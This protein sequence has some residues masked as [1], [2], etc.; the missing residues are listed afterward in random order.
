MPCYNDGIVSAEALLLGLAVGLGVGVLLVLA[1]VRRS[2]G[3][4]PPPL[5]PRVEQA[6]SSLPQLQQDLGGMKATLQG[7]PS[8]AVVHELAVR[9]ASLESQVGERV[10]STLPTDLQGLTESLTRLKT[11]LEERSKRDAALETTLRKIEGVV[12][13]AQ[14][15]GAAGEVVLAEAFANFPAEMA[16]HNFKVNGK[17]VEF[18]LV[19][20]NRKRLP[21]D[22]KWP[23]SKELEQYANASE[24]AERKELLERI[25]RAVLRKVEEVTKYI[26][27]ASTVNAAVAAVPDAAY[28]ACRTAHIEAYQ[29]RVLLMPYSLT[30]PFLL[31]LYNLHLQFARSIDFDNLDAYLAQ[32]EVHLSAV[33]E[34]LDN[35]IERGA[36]M[37][38]NAYQEVRQRIGHMRVLL[39]QLR[40]MP[41]ES[42]AEQQESLL[43]STE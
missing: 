41:T 37:V 5:D 23:A 34:K 6:L 30:I 20:P 19:L 14:S 2:S 9:L 32:V 12:A 38:L 21:I 16:D 17:T 1:W 35:S 18:A 3:T 31:A 10:P 25:E 8:N 33:D 13:G 42:L 15:R 24:E 27:P 40:R 26:D 22:S 28:F 11:Q 43:K 7:L 29:K 4:T 36:T 39:N